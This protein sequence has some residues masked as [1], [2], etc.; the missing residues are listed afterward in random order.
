[1]LKQKLTQVLP[2]NLLKE[3]RIKLNESSF[4]DIFTTMEFKELN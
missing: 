1:M 4:S 2:L 3:A